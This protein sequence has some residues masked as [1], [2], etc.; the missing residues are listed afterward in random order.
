M[1]PKQIGKFWSRYENEEAPVPLFKFKLIGSN[2]VCRLNE[3]LKGDG[4]AIID[5]GVT[6]GGGVLGNYGINSNTSAGGFLKC[7]FKKEEKLK[8]VG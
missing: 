7:T 5:Q 3:L 2:S 4:I 8:A 1:L 6:F